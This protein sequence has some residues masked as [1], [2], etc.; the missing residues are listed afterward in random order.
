MAG[1]VK[2]S[3]TEASD[4]TTV[5][6]DVGLAGKIPMNAQHTELRTPE[7]HVR[8]NPSPP[9]VEK[10]PP[11]L[12][13]DIQSKAL[14]RSE[15]GISDTSNS[16]G[17]RKRGKVGVKKSTK[18]KNR[19]KKLRPAKKTPKA[20]QASK[21]KDPTATVAP[22]DSS[23]PAQ[24]PLSNPAVPS[25]QGT[26]LTASLQQVK[27]EAP[28]T[29]APQIPQDPFKDHLPPHNLLNRAN[30][31]DKM[32]LDNLKDLVKQ[33]VLTAMGD[34]K[35]GN[36]NNSD[37]ASATSKETTAKKNNGRDKLEKNRRMRFYRSLVSNLTLF[38]FG[39]FIGVFSKSSS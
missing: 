1:P 15:T 39:D 28:Q 4:A 32:D 8:L 14:F 35:G 11:R 22:E 30:T 9:S 18:L 38:M 12:N 23:L 2:R 37:A 5:P 21:P 29:P 16:Q 26:G 27:P 17:V 31:T 13:P 6:G 34:A 24:A 3:P 33:S 7:S 25:S 36:G 19:T 20:Q 10:G